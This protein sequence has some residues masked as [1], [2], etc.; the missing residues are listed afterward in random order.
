MWSLRSALLGR[1]KPRSGVAGDGADNITPGAPT[2]PSRA[3]PTQWPQHLLA[4]TDLEVSDVGPKQVLLIG[5][6]FLLDWGDVLQRLGYDDLSI[7]R[8]LFFNLLRLPAS[9]PK[10]VETYDVQLVQIPLP[11]VMPEQE[12]MRLPADDPRPYE[13]LLDSCVGRLDLFLAE[14][15]VWSNHIPT[16]VMT[17]LSPQ[18]NLL[19]RLL[20]RY[21]LR[22]PIHFT[23]RLNMELDGL[24]KQ[25]RNVHLLDTNHIASV[26]G[27]R[28]MQGDAFWQQHH[29]GLLA[30]TA[31]ELW[32]AGRRIEK[33]PP[34]AEVLGA[35]VDGFVE[36]VWQELRAAY[37]T[38]R[39]ADEVK[40][41]CV[42]LDDTLW[43]G[44]IG[45]WDG[46]DRAWILAGW[47]EGLLEILQYL[48]RRGVILAIVSKNDEA[49]V[50][51]VWPKMFDEGLLRLEDF[52]IVKINWRPKAENIAEAMAEANLLPKS[53][54]F[55]D[56]NPVERSAVKAAFPEIRTLETSHFRWSRVLGWSP[57]LQVA[58]ISD[59]SARR[60]QLIQAQVERQRVRAALSRED[61]L[62]SLNLRIGV[63]TL[64]AATDS[65]FARAFEL[66]NKTNQFNTTGV[67][68][69]EGDTAAYFAR[70]G[71]WWT[72]EVVD[73]FTNY[74]LVGV[75]C[76][77][78][79]QVDQFV[80]SC[81]VAGLDAELAAL[82]VILGCTAP[83]GAEFDGFVKE[84]KNNA[85]SRDIFARLGWSRVDSIPSVSTAAASAQSSVP[86]W[87]LTGIIAVAGATVPPADG[88]RWRGPAP[89]ALPAHVTLMEPVP[90]S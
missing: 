6:C 59:E 65:R 29:G 31:D 9:P 4:P 72:F 89:N 24:L 1:A 15:L 64:R 50:R 18:Q 41:L 36:M 25:Y 11:S 19:G 74:G 83:A 73:R 68:W 42:D 63:H 27:R 51:S 8:L 56:D 16:F 28:F 12:Y 67:R 90:Q 76:M 32:D 2:T 21:D 61:F 70:G 52:A 75:V 55:L 14:A 79:T 80:M 48:K 40:M 54:V 86:V 47:P 60:T 87:T 5:A 57:E 20:P 71:V 17:Y 35:A 69:L 84:T 88:E 39:R 38:L 3:S 13:A 22:N 37:R 44:L 77:Q 58:Q 45:E 85:V 34:V 33:S 81:R 78:G 43:R 7:D 82:S 26:Y 10:P 30:T 49:H 62:A 23:E 46:N 66:L 53:V